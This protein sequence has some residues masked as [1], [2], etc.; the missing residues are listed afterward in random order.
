MAHANPSLLPASLIMAMRITM[1]THLIRD[2]VQR[3]NLRKLMM[4]NLVAHRLFFFLSRSKR[5]QR[6]PQL[7]SLSPVTRPPRAFNQSMFRSSL[8]C[9]HA[10]LLTF[11]DHLSL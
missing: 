10:V 11:W 5:Y 1:L 4:E 9:I 3:M 6:C 2:L 7:T 8:L